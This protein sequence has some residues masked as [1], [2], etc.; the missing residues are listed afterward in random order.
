MPDPG[1]RRDAGGASAGPPR[2][3]VC[4]IFASIQGESSFAGWPCTF[5]RLTGCPL[6]CWYC[7]TEYAFAEGASLSITEVLARVADCGWPLVELTGGEPLAQPAA[8][9]LAARLCDRGHQVLI[10]TGGGVSIA[11][12]DERVHIILDIKT[13]DSGMSDRQDPGNLEHLRP[14]DELK[15]VICSRQDYLWSRAFIAERGLAD[16]YRVHFSPVTIPAGVRVRAAAT[17]EV[18]TQEAAAQEVAARDAAGQNAGVRPADLAQWI[19]EDRLR[20]R[21]NMQLHRWI[22]GAGARGV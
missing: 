20:V 13:P 16:R 18:A 14:H 1:P 12:R 6:R 8:F 10:E 17:Q 5:V 15:F 2:L 19:L 22:W 9:L 11:G 3:T 21:L 4:E 7:D